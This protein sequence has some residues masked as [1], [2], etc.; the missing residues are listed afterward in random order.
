MFQYPNKHE[1]AQY[2][3]LLTMT[4]WHEQR[5]VD[6]SHCRHHSALH[7]H[8]G[9]NGAMMSDLVPCTSIFQKGSSTSASFADFETL[10]LGRLSAT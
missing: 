9:Y 8:A 7:F 3:V 1:N 4:K 10:S 5:S 6:I 2:R